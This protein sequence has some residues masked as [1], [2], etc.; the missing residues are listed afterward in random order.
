MVA[1]AAIDGQNLEL[2]PRNHPRSSPRTAPLAGAGAASCFLPERQRTH[3][4][5]SEHSM[6]REGGTSV[7]TRPCC[8]VEAFA[9]AMICHRQYLT[10][11]AGRQGEDPQLAHDKCVPGTPSGKPANTCSMEPALGSL[12]QSIKCHHAIFPAALRQKLPYISTPAT[13]GDE[14]A[15]PQSTVPYRTVPYRTEPNR[16]CRTP[17]DTPSPQGFG[18]PSRPACRDPPHR[19]RGECRRRLGKA[20]PCT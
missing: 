15:T 20:P 18:P 1:A 7:M 12:R 3:P 8:S 2:P 13:R 6:G 10:N 4:L 16:T 14:H 11:K 19:C 17:P 9:A 5:R